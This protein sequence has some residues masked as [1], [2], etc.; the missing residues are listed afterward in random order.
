[1][2][3]DVVSHMAVSLT[4]EHIEAVIGKMPVQYRT[5]IRL[6]L[7][8]YLDVSQEDVE[9][10]AADQP[11]S[12]FPSGLQ[13]DNK[14]KSFL[15]GVQSVASRA[16]QYRQLY[17]QKRER[18][19]WEIKCLQGQI[20]H[21]ETLISVTS[22][23]LTSAGLIDRQTLD[24]Y[25]Q[26]AS[27]ALAKPAI[28]QLEK[29]WD[30]EEVTEEQYK[31]ER[32]LIEYQSLIRR[33]VWYKRR[34]HGTERD[35]IAAGASPLRDH[36]IAH[37]WGIPLGSLAGRKVKALHHYLIE[38]QKALQ[39]SDTAGAPSTESHAAQSP[40]LWKETLAVLNRS[41][42]ERSIVSYG[43]LERS[44]EQ[45]MEK[46]RQFAHGEMPEE[47]EPKFWL[48]I[49]RIKDVEHGG[50]WE[51]H[52]RSIFALQKLHAIQM[53]SDVTLEDIE[54]KLRALATPKS[55]AEA[56]PALEPGE[57]PLELSE[58][59]LG[60]LQAFIGEQDDKRRT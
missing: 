5:M 44:E 17:R 43:G 52:A 47:A 18:P 49:T 31:K 42:V 30:K 35:F 3:P 51:N 1:M 14:K 16:A 12:R 45:L 11:D 27:S 53:D 56:V 40:D 13:P 39:D 7:L 20:K 55:L 41:S 15:E 9:Y 33:L 24:D 58:Q 22:R 48:E 10:M 19:W 50:P 29:A 23:M 34:L 60:V 26:R 46:L 38:L 4:K 28:R 32:L 6:L 37:I 21:L 2:H 36:E 25:K 59:G 8:Q 57:K 54:Q